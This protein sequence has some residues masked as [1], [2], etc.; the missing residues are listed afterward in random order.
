M[1][2]RLTTDRSELNLVERL[3]IEGLVAW[4]IIA[5]FAITIIAARFLRDAYVAAGLSDARAHIAVFLTLNATFFAAC[6]KYWSRSIFP[7][8][9]AGWRR[10]TRAR[11]A[12]IVLAMQLSVLAF[13]P[14]GL[15]LMV[16]LLL[17]WFRF[18][19]D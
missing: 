10:R 4:R 7:F 14:L 8:A 16:A 6:Y 19:T 9:P 13:A 3:A 5:M 2:Y 15:Q 18:G 1:R 12:I 11:I 17:A